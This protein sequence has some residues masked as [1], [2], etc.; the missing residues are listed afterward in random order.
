MSVQP[1]RL[2][3]AGLGLLVAPFVVNE[4]EQ[5]RAVQTASGWSR[6]AGEALPPLDGAWRVFNSRWRV[7]GGTEWESAS[8]TQVYAR[9]TL[10]AGSTLGLSLAATETDGLWVWLKA[11]EPVTATRSGAPVVCM[12][13]IDSGNELTSIELR[14]QPDAVLLQWGEDTMICPDP[15]PPD[16]GTLRLR[17]DGSSLSIASIGR[18]RNADGLPMSPLWWAASIVLWMLGWMLAA[19]LVT[20]ILPRRPTKPLPEEE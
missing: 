9:S 14:R 2:A 6:I 18:E 16:A 20:T 5:M 8:S 3:I 15:T 7:S 10:P 19:D 13:G 11:N 12:G 1:R 17:V 4:L